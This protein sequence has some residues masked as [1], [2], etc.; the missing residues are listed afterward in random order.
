[1][2]EQMAIRKAMEL[3]SLSQAQL[4]KRLGL[5]GQAI[6][7]QRLGDKR[8]SLKV[9]TF[10]EMMNACGFDVI[11]KDRMSP[12]QWIIGGTGGE[13]EEEDKAE[14]EAAP[15]EP[16]PTPTPVAAPDPDP[17]PRTGKKIKLYSTEK[18]IEMG[19]ITIEYAIAHGWKP[20]PEFIDRLLAGVGDE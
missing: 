18:L 12:T 7:A 10:V 3:R 9:D 20:S 19:A 16:E 5:S 1:M 6:V 15:T 13:G 8:K 17:A 14:A 2:N 4:A 11:V